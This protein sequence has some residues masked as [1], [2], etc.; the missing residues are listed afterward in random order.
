MAHK[1][2]MFQ[3]FKLYWHH[4]QYNNTNI[5]VSNGHSSTFVEWVTRQKEAYHAGTLDQGKI[6]VLEELGFDW[7]LDPPAT[8][9]ELFQVLVQYHERFESTL[10]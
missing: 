5:A 10:F 9:D 8:W 3:Y 6:D 7:T 2:W 4:Q 1:G